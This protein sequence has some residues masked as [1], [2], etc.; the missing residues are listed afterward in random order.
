LAVKPVPGGVNSRDRYEL[1]AEVEGPDG[2][3]S[4]GLAAEVEHF[5]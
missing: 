1:V 5:F 2:G 4:E 3:S